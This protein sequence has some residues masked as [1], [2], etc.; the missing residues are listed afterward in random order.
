MFQIRFQNLR[1]IYFIT[2]DQWG[3]TVSDTDSHEFYMLEFLLEELEEKV[4]EENKRAQQQE[5][6]YKKQSSSYS[7]QKLPKMDV[8][9]FGSGNYGG[10]KTPK[11]NI[12][13]I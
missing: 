9:K 1:K 6:E 11:V 8:P 3:W 10:F 5:K 13:K 2:A 12:P 4:K 7:K